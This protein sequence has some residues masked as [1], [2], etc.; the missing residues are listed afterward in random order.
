MRMPAERPH[1]PAQSMW[2][3]RPV[4]LVVAMVLGTLVLFPVSPLFWLWFGARVS[5]WTTGSGALTAQVALLILA[6]LIVTTVAVAKL[7]GFLN[8]THMELTG[9][10][11]GRTQARAWNKSMRDDRANTRDRGLLEIIMVATV[12]AACLMLFVW[13][14]LNPHIT[15]PS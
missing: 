8:R 3:P 1:T 6:G 2:A 4:L 10:A 15:L 5:F 14:L 12:A 7:L 13:W 9:L 11:S